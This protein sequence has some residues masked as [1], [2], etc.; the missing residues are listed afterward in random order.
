M[1]VFSLFCLVALFFSCKQN[2]EEESNNVTIDS[3]VQQNNET[4]TLDTID[5]KKVVPKIDTLE[6]Q[7]IDAGLIDIQSVDSTIKID[8]RYTTKNNFMKMDLYGGLN[9]IYLQ[10]EV[11]ERLSKAQSSLKRKDS[12]LTLLV[13]DGVRPRL[14]QQ[15][16]WDALDTIPFNERIK[17]VSNPKNG[18]LHNYGC[19]VDLTIMNL[20]TGEVLDMGAGYDD[21]RKIAYPKHEAAFLESG[22]LSKE[23]FKNRKLLRSAMK[24]GGFWVLS[25]E[26]WHFNAFTREKAKE[27]YDIV[28]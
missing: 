14:V 13:Y 22:E 17:F 24:K 8:L 27:L 21:L 3:I 10:K 20:K 7:I 19:A 12:N 16:M 15:K 25:T 28:E 18:S 4:S 2:Q 23:Q 5:S 6:Q 26:W 11:A 9:K 1:R